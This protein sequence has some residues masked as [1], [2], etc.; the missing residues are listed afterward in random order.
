MD[1]GATTWENNSPSP[2]SQPSAQASSLN[3]TPGQ[4]QPKIYPQP[5]PR[6]QLQPKSQSQTQDTTQVKAN[7]SLED[8]S[9]YHHHSAEGTLKITIPFKCMTFYININPLH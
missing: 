3:A 1:R 7:N 4:N 8:G 6:S 9:E 5:Q 2:A